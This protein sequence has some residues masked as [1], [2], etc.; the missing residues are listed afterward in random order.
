[1]SVQC[2]A[3]VLPAGSMMHVAALGSHPLI[4][5]TDSAGRECWV[6]CSAVQCSAVQCSAVQCNAVQG[7]STGCI[8]GS[9]HPRSR[10]KAGGAGGRMARR[11]GVHV[12]PVLFVLSHPRA[13]AVTAHVTARQTDVRN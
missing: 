9:L 10:G 11:V 13:C 8:F 7:A 3:V 5:R 2:S 12:K 4:L 6:H 1:M